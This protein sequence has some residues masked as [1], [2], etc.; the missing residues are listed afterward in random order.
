MSENHD[1]WYMFNN[2]NDNNNGDGDELESYK[3]A[4]EQP[5]RSQYKPLFKDNNEFS[6]EET[7]FFEDPDYDD[8]FYEDE[9]ISED[10]ELKYVNEKLQVF[11]ESSTLLWSAVSIALKQRRPLIADEYFKRLAAIPIKKHGFDTIIFEITYMLCDPFGRATQIRKCVRFLQK[12]YPKKEE[13]L[14]YEG[15]LEEQMGN[16]E[17]ASKLFRLAIENCKRAPKSAEHLSNLMLEDA[18]DIETDNVDELRQSY[19]K[20]KQILQYRIDLLKPWGNE[21]E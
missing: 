5:L 14:Y 6:S 17:K 10:N 3:S 2:D 16:Y 21:I 1:P 11:P 12:K 19:E 8:G 9:F 15:V 18:E 4:I 7:E 20:L 13:G